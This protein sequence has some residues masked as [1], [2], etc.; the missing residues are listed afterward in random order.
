MRRI[1]VVGGRDLPQRAVRIQIGEEGP[2]SGET[3]AAMFRVVE[4][5]NFNGDYPDEQWVGPPLR[6][7]AAANRVAATF[8]EEVTGESRRYF[9]VVK[10]PYTLQP[11]FVP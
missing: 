2:R 9:K 1:E 8:N 6:D 11:G 7:E 4:T 3:E 10:L 5:D